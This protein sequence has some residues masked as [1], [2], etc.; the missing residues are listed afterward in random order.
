MTSNTDHIDKDNPEWTTDDFKKAVPFSALPDHL[1]QTLKPNK[2]PISIRLSPEVLD[3]FK[4]TGKGW[5]GRIDAVLK[6]Y[7][8][9]Q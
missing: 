8:A 5:Q 1:Q 2:T 4:A 6:D 3:Y 9:R 7:V